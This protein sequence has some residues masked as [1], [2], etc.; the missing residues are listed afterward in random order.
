MTLN[1]IS[2]DMFLNI[3]VCEATKLSEDKFN[4]NVTLDYPVTLHRIIYIKTK[5]FIIEI[6]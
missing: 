2:G 4:R 1:H 6:I 5:D 3:S